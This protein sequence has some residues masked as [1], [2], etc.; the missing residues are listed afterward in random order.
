MQ[1]QITKHCN[2]TISLS[3]MWTTGQG[4]VKSCFHLMKEIGRQ[5]NKENQN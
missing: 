3:E 1:N 2:A 5:K 4:I